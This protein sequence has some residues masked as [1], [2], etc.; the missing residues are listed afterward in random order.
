MRIP[1]SRQKITSKDVSAVTK[2]LKSD[3]LTQ[4]RTIEIFEKEICKKVKAKY[5]VAANSGTSALHIGCLALGLKSKDYLWTVGNSF[6]ASANCGRYCGANVE[7]IDINP[8]TFNIDPEILEKK[9]KE[10][11]KNKIPKILV[12]VH[13]TGEPAEMKKIY[14][15]KKKYKFKIIEDASHALG[16][17]IKKDPVGS[18]KYS[19]LTVFSFH[20][21]KSITTAEGGVATTNNKEVFI[22]MQLLRNHGITRNINLLKKKNK[23]YW[24]YE[25]QLL[26]FNYRMNDLE[27]AL[28]VSQLKNLDSFIKERRKIVKNYRELLKDLPLD[29]QKLT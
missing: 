28:G 24:Y 9:L 23:S 26:G 11:P 12:V 10:T 21:V 3:F 1:Y 19:D 7:F 17:K 29:F 25:Q 4:G 6:V 18:C 2:I 14:N 13:F 5:G 20:P 27:A 15:L 8:K 22:K 16:A